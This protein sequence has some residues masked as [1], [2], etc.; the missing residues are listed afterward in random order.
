MMTTEVKNLKGSSLARSKVQQQVI[1]SLQKRHRQ[2]KLFRGAGVTAV[3][4]SLLL[5]VLLFVNIFS[6]G[7]PAF[8][9]HAIKVDIYF[10]PA[11]VQIAEKPVQQADESDNDFRQRDLE[12]RSSVGMINF[13]RLILDGLNKVI[14]DG[15][16]HRR[17][18][19]RVVTSGER[20][21]IRVGAS[22]TF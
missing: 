20:F 22:V 12:W 5:V 14:P 3:A 18:L 13:N 10:D 7:L 15:Q 2:E 8:W 21:A 9:Q 1:N 17:D 19:Q 6:K 11:V 4:I 16:A